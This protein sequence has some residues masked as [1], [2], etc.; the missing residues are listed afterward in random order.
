[1]LTFR[2][3]ITKGVNVSTSDVLAT[4]ALTVSILAAV[5]SAF[6][7]LREHWDSGQRRALET[8]YRLQSEDVVKARSVVGNVLR[9]ESSNPMNDEEKSEYISATF[10]V[11][12][13]ISSTQLLSRVIGKKQS[14]FKRLAVGNPRIAPEESR[15][16]YWHITRMVEDISP[17]ML[18]FPYAD[19]SESAKEVNRTL[20]SLPDKILSAMGVELISKPLTR[21]PESSTATETEGSIA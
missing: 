21:L 11:M 17:A 4:A 5:L 16:V 6:G 19:W 3:L 15:A 14:R 9:R 12:W 20:D 10:I 7:L 1:M 13:A 2:Q 18:K 8:A